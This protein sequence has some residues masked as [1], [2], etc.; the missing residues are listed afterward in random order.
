VT[1]VL[2]SF[3][4]ALVGMALFFCF[5][6]MLSIPVLMVIAKLHDPSAPLQSPDVVLA[7]SA[8]FRTAGLPLSAVAFALCFA[9]ALKKFR[10]R[11]AQPPVS[12]T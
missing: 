2:K 11:S 9:L 5:F 10:K 6:M 4:V 12:R 8:W 1:A 7:P 3:A